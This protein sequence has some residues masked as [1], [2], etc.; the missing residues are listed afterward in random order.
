[1]N[2]LGDC[3]EPQQT[4]PPALHPQ[5]TAIPTGGR[6]KLNDFT[7]ELCDYTNK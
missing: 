3:S 7:N 5:E 2:M 1:M 4:Q 6:R